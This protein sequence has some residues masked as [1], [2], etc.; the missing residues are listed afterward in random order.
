MP[1]KRRRGNWGAG[2]GGE[3]ID[4][5]DEGRITGLLSVI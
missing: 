4:K 2:E 1:W 3:V 5:D